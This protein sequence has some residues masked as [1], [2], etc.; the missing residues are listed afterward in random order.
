MKVSDA[1]MK[2]LILQKLKEVEEMYEVQ[3]LY[4]VES[5]SRAWGFPS[6]N[7]DFDVRFIYIHHPH[8]YLA[9]DPQGVGTKRDVIELPINTLLDMNGWEITKALRL[10]RKSNPPLFEWLGSD[11]VYYQ[12]Y[13]FIEKLRLLE[14][15]VFNPVAILHHYL[16][17][18]KSNYKKYLQGSEVKLKIYF[19]VLRSI[20]ACLWI[21]KYNAVPPVAFRELL[22]EMILEEDLKSKIEHLLEWKKSGEEFN[23]ASQIKPINDF[24]EK[25]IT[26]MEEYVKTLTLE[27]NNPTE[28]L[29]HLFRET[30]KEVWENDKESFEQ[31]Q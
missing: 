20:F 8:W 9:I 22:Q 15:E 7:S 4:A 21:K 5:G 23:F 19:Y 30:L 26:S 14:P 31:R 2:E 29:N 27:I 18:A 3:V 12:K 17:I 10:F 11:N 28:R 1:K 25:E 13:L 6:K 24:L 16:N